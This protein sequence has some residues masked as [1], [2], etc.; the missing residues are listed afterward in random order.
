MPRRVHR[1]NGARGGDDKSDPGIA[2]RSLNPSA[3]MERRSYRTRQRVA[4]AGKRAP[5]PSLANDGG[6]ATNVQ[7]GTS[8]TARDF[9]PAIRYVRSLALRP[10]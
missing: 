10:A 8:V 5:V 7:N 4:S 6:S 3:L 9:G 2:H 1:D